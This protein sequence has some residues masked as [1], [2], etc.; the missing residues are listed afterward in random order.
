[1]R[2]VPM[3]IGIIPE[4][5][6]LV[7]MEA[8]STRFEAGQVHLPKGAPW[9][10]TFLHEILAFPNLCHDDQT[11]SVSQFLNWAEVDYGL[12]SICLDPSCPPF[13]IIRA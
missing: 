6:K 9:L 8:Q 10:S 7:R 2:G 1:V 5:S 11:D 3:P 13:Q 12:D 4:G